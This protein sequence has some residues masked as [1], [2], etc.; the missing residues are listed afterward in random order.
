MATKL[1]Q[2]KEKNPRFKDTD[3]EVLLKMLHANHFR[4]RDYEE[5]KSQMLAPIEEERGFTDYVK[6]VGK[7]V[8]TGASDAVEEIAQ[9]VGSVRQGI[10]NRFPALKAL[11]PFSSSVGA[12]KY[13]EKHR[14]EEGQDPL[15]HALKNV[16]VPDAGQAETLPGQL[17]QGITQFLTGYALAGSV[18]KLPANASKFAKWGHAM[19]KGAFSDAFAFDPRDPNFANFLHEAGVPRNV[20]TDYLEADENDSEAE[21]RFKKALE[22]T[23]F[24]T[25]TEM[26]V[27]SLSRIKSGWNAKRAKEALAE[28]EQKVATP[29]EEEVVLRRGSEYVPER[30][31]DIEPSQEI[32]DIMSGKV[33]ATPEGDRLVNTRLENYDTEDSILAALQKGAKE[34]RIEKKTMSIDEV[35]ESAKQLGL[36]DSEVLK[37][38]KEYSDFP[39]LIAYT[40]DTLVTRSEVLKEAATKAMSGNLED[41]ARFD[42][43]F[44]RQ[45]MI[46]DSVTQQA[47]TAGRALRMYRESAKAS[48]DTIENLRAIIEKRGGEEKVRDMAKYLSVLD[49]LDAQI[50]IGRQIYKQPTIM[51]GVAE[52]IIN[53]GFLSGLS[54]HAK[55]IISNTVFNSTTMAE[56]QLAAQLGRLRRD[57]TDKVSQEEANAYIAA[58]F[59]AS[60]DSIKSFITSFG[61]DES[62]ILLNNR[63]I[64][65]QLTKIE[66]DAHKSIGRDL[67]P[68]GSPESLKRGVDALG[69]YARLPGRFL[70]AQ[71][72]MFKTLAYR[73]ELTAQ[74]IRKANKLKSEGKLT[75]DIGDYVA[76]MISNPSKELHDHALEYSRE[77]TFTNR[78]GETGQGVI[79]FANSHPSLRL[80]IPFIR[81]PTNLVKQAAQRNIITA[82]LMREWREEIAAGGARRDIAIA[83]V[84]L[85][86][87][88]ATGVMILAA[89]GYITGSPPRDPELR[90]AFYDS[91]KQP[92]S[93][94]DPIT[95]E[96]VSYAG[97]DPWATIFGLAADATNYSS[98]ATEAERE[99]IAA[100]M[101]TGI[102]QNI[103]EKSWMEGANNFFEALNGSNGKNL[104]TWVKDL[105]ASAAV[106]NYLAQASRTIDPA[107]RHNETLLD[108]IRRR[109]PGFSDTLPARHNVWGEVIQFDGV[110]GPD[111]SG[112]VNPFFVSKDTN[113]KIQQFVWDSRMEITMPRKKIGGV[114][115]TPR[116]Y[117]RYVV[118]AGKPAFE[119]L[120][121]IANTPAWDKMPVSVRQKL[122]ST[123][124]EKHRANAQK[125]ML[126]EIHNEYTD[127]RIKE[128]DKL[129][130]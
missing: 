14:L 37:L 89:D 38:T 82:P 65:D 122:V 115:L 119:Q 47:T 125:Q 117:E 9:S 73:Q 107:L 99:D 7:S 21:A 4:D 39:A 50:K 84:T 85:G 110:W 124:I 123:V 25:A 87:S 116:Q 88:V 3:D 12:R 45:M 97:L 51:D 19:A 33:E 32:R 94:K 36:S 35:Y 41:M 52:W 49:D 100:H 20:V 62:F 16:D 58:A 86:T 98:Y 28:A 109:V 11:D 101:I 29:G 91:G 79:K 40:R 54:T 53:Q 128:I 102:A 2:Y 31:R 64:Q 63:S 106:P 26:V 1:D 60:G 104:G 44:A 95:G 23:M 46:L 83:K 92:Y 61:K 70:I 22:G 15:A 113:S 43:E 103:M 81:T 126:A 74:A 66:V 67:L 71:D 96:W 10:L 27:R 6:D 56:R 5:F 114:E 80:I 75:E 18:G 78:L 77:L 76:K 120:E 111:W 130:N 93:I 72:A 24:G 8:V 13:R 57:S 90:R 127:Q 55:N 34:Y 108:S 112:P 121:R 68:S 59:Q 118:L 42:E 69:I 17:T 48:K 105:A 30:Y 129:L